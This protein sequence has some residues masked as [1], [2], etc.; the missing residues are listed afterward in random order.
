MDTGKG[1]KKNGKEKYPSRHPVLSEAKVE[2]VS[3]KV[4]WGKK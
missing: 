1:S 4:K 3:L 2:T